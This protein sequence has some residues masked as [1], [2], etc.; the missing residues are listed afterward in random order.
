VVGT[1]YF[2]TPLLQQCLQEFN[3]ELWNDLEER[4]KLGGGERALIS[5][6]CR[7]HPQTPY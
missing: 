6:E 5:N 7:P 1:L 2:T 4:K 3:S